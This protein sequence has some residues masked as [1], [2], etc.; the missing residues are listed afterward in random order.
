VE[1]AGQSLGEQVMETFF[2]MLGLVAFSALVIYA[3]LFEPRLGQ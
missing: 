3:F 2:I 1:K